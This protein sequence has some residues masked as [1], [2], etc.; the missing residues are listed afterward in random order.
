MPSRS[1][2][3]QQNTEKNKTFQAQ[4]KLKLRFDSPVQSII[5]SDADHIHAQVN[6]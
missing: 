1:T 5:V 3:N 2:N 4:E 6:V